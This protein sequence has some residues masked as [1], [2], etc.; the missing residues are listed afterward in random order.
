MIEKESINRILFDFYSVVDIDIG[1]ARLMNTKYNNPGFINPQV[2]NKS[3]ETYKILMLN[4]KYYNPLVM[5]LNEQ[6]RAE[7]NN[8][9][10]EIMKTPD[11]FKE[12]LNMSITTSIFNILQTAL[13]T[14]SLRATVLCWNEE[15][16]N[17]IKSLLKDVDTVVFDGNPVDIKDFDTLIFKVPYPNSF[18]TCGNEAVNGKNIYICKYR[19]NMNEN[20]TNKLEIND[21]IKL[22]HMNANV[23]YIIEV[24]ANATLTTNQEEI[25]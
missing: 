7:A 20:D 19:F 18:F 3:I 14:P 2:L 16:S 1:I 4:R 17:Y 23:F 10:S 15:Q 11:V 5:F 13:V 22:Y 6:Y 21:E 8:I 25:V 12:V 24:Y 9:N